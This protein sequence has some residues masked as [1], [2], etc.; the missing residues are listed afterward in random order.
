MNTTIDLQSFFPV[1]YF[2]ILST[3]ERKDSI[4]IKLK[5][6]T[7]SCLCHVCGEKTTKYHGTYTR[8]VQNLPMIGK[9]VYLEIIAHEYIC[10]NTNCKSK[11]IL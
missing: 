6:I 1:K 2:E 8:K 7:K 11:T 5:S 3:N 4:K 9:S 10:C